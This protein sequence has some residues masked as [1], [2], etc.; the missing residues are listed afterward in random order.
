LKRVSSFIPKPASNARQFLSV[1]SLPEFPA[2]TNL[3]SKL[4]NK[5][6]FTSTLSA[7]FKISSKWRDNNSQRFAHDTRNADAAKRLLDLES[8]IHVTDEIWNRIAP[9]VQDDGACLSAI[10]ETNR[11]VEFKERPAD[12]SAWLESFCTILSRH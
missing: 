4:N 5:P 11:L 12:F 6:V 1:A 7:Q 3:R 10:S 8:Q 2:I 9:L